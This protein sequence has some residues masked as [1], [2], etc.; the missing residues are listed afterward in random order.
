MQIYWHNIQG[1]TAQD[2]LVAL[3]DTV[4]PALLTAPTQSCSA[5]GAWRVWTRAFSIIPLWP[6]PLY[7]G[8]AGPFCL[9]QRV[10]TR[11]K[12]QKSNGDEKE[13]G[14][15]IMIVKRR[16]IIYFVPWNRRRQRT[17]SSEA[18]IWIPWREVERPDD[19]VHVCLTDISQ[20]QP[21]PANH[22][23]RVQHPRATQRKRG[24]LATSGHASWLLWT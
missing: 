21:R 15:N 2:G 12:T 24:E 20:R 16:K 6:Q 11:V 17:A 9:N 8:N 19:V 13:W 4:Y 22:H 23:V 14:P 3:L 5:W 7:F 1:K 10:T 18:L